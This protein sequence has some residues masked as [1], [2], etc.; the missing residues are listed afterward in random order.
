MLTST[1]LKLE[2]SQSRE[3]L[4]VLSAMDEA[5]ETETKEMDDLTSSYTGLEKRYQAAVLSEG[6]KETVEDITETEPDSEAKELFGLVCRAK[7]GNYL[8]KAASGRTL[9]GAELELNKGLKVLA[10]R[11]PVSICCLTLWNRTTETLR[12]ERTRQRI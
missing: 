2:M 10:D 8:E 5:G 4:A 12:N 9:D 1:K 7:I 6:E 11:L 3:R